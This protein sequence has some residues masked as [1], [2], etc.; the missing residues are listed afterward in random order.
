M[1][2]PLDRFRL[3][4]LTCALFIVATGCGDSAGPSPVP[5]GP[6]PPQGFAWV[7]FDADTVVAEVANSPELQQQ[8]LMNRDEVPAGTGMLFV[9]EQE[10]TQ[11]FY[12][13]N[14]YV[15]LDIA[16]LD[17]AQIVV[18]IQQMEPLTENL[19]QSASP[20]LLA[21]EVPQGWFASQGIGV[22]DIAEIVYGRM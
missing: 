9:F 6:R 2:S 14:T 5:D 1:R 21:L 7:I 8:G 12:M 18:D 10:R 16:F 4:S 13:R 17:E 15:P 22:G 20:A 3:P 11:S 19:H